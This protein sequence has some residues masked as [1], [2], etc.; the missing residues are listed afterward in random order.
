MLL[1]SQ[2][3]RAQNPIS[4]NYN[5]STNTVSVKINPCDPCIL[6]GV[7]FVPACECGKKAAE[8]CASLLNTPSANYYGWCVNDYKQKNCKDSPVSTKKI[9]SCNYGMTFYYNVQGSRPTTSGPRVYSPGGIIENSMIIPDWQPTG[10][11]F[12]LPANAS[13][14]IYFHVVIFFSNGE[15]CHFTETKC[16]SNNY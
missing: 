4:I 11:A 6:G 3:L 9:S 10:S 5:V 1:S 14:C 7:E 15:T 2:F 13:G 8:S 12:P 16:F